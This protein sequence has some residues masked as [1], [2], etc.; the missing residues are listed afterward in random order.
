MIK[1]K[2]NIISVA[3]LVIIFAISIL[4]VLTNNTKEVVSQSV[5][6][7]RESNYPSLSLKLKALSSKLEST[8]NEHIILKKKIVMPTN[9]VDYVLFHKIDSKAALLGKDDWLFYKTDYDGNPIEDYKGTN[10]YSE[11]QLEQI[12]KNVKDKQEELKQQHIDFYMLIPPNKEQVYSN[13]MPDDI[14]IENEDRKVD[15][16]IRYLGENNVKVINPKDELLEMKDKCQVYYKNDTHWNKLG[17]F[18][19]TQQINQEILGKR[20]ILE[21]DKVINSGK[22]KKSDLLDILEM[23]KFNYDAEY[24]Y[25]SESNNVNTDY[26]SIENNIDRFT[27]NAKSDKKI[28]VIGDSFRL[29]LEEWIPKYYSKVDFIHRSDFKS[30]LIKELKPDIVIYEIVERKTD[31]LLTEIP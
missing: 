10:P 5:N 18:I 8:Y 19:G 16:L 24:D 20:E 28:L 2:N 12:T 22:A 7:V 14:S 31:E 3:F 21:S 25:S 6:Q 27:S 23:S 30:D 26:K 29:A 4:T 1:N 13:Y 11:E 15:K 17:A 9:I